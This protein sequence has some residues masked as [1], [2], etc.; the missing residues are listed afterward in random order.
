MI[1]SRH[2]SI[3]AYELSPAT[4]PIRHMRAEFNFSV[5]G[6]NSSYGGALCCGIPLPGWLNWG[7][8]GG[9]ANCE[10]ALAKNGILVILWFCSS[11][12]LSLKACRRVRLLQCFLVAKRSH[13]SATIPMINHGILTVFHCKLKTPCCLLVYVVC[14]H[15]L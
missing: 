7:G 10:K 6:W 13:K 1:S 3:E 11:M 14:L 4:F 9:G 12:F 15:M 8:G 2:D 5:R